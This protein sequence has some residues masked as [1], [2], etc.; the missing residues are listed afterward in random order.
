VFAN[1][2]AD[3]S[4]ITHEASRVFSAMLDFRPIFDRSCPNPFLTGDL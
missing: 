1:D 3:F 2:L 4:V